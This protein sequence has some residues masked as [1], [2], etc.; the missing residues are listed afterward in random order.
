MIVAWFGFRIQIFYFSCCCCCFCLM[1][2]FDPFFF[3]C[4]FVFLLCFVSMFPNLEGSILLSV[5]G[6]SSMVGQKYNIFCWRSQCK[7][8]QF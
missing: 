7:T 2:C 5:C 3:L 4:F 8:R 1:N 6:R